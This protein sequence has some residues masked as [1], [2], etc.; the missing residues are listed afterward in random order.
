MTVANIV[1][2]KW[3]DKYPAHYVNRLF[4]GVKRFLRRD[5]RFVCFT[6]RPEGI[7]PG[8][9]IEP[10]PAEP[11]DDALVTMMDSAAARSKGMKWG[12]WRKISLYKA[13]RLNL[14]GPVLGLDVD[15]VITGPLDELIDFAPGKVCM[16][17]DWKASR[18]SLPYCNSSVFRFEPARHHYI[19]DEFAADPWGCALRAD[20][21]EQQH[22]SMTALAHG[23][24]AYFPPHW[25]SSYKSQAIPRWP[26]N[27]IRPPRI[28]PGS[29]VMC[30]YGDLKMEQALNGTPWPMKNAALPAPWLKDFWLHERE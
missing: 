1:C 4:L 15:V 10:L 18:L 14:E 26:L 25:I 30:F 2:I 28:P 20:G 5:F 23:D 27:W 21:Q 19:Y 16:R 17:R 12:A 29:R 13:G 3:G 11:F 8:I 9:E 22:S 6:E 7:G 24:L